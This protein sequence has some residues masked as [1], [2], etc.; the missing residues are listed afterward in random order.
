MTEGACVRSPLS[1]SACHHIGH[2]RADIL[3]LRR[4]VV[5]PGVIAGSGQRPAPLLDAQVFQKLRGVINVLARVEHVHDG[6]E[7]T[8][9]EMVVDLHAADVDELGAGFA[10]LLEFQQGFL[11]S[12]RKVGWPFDI[13]RIGVQ[14]AAPPGLG[15]RDGIK[16]AERHPIF[17]RC[18]RHLALANERVVRLDAGRV[19][20]RGAGRVERL[21]K[22][23]DRRQQGCEQPKTA[24]NP[25]FEAAV[26]EECRFRRFGHYRFHSTIRH[27]T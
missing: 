23:K 24:K 16:D 18:A 21:A 14:R 20:R 22:C 15:Q 13:E 26:A 8:P 6:V 12:L 27:S 3:L 7:M 5:G 19:S 1:E 17:R 11:Q 9:V 4:I 10:R 2:D 25:P